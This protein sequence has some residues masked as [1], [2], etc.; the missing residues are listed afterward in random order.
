[1]HQLPFP[2]SN[3]IVTSPFELIHADLWGTAPLVASNSFRFY[4]VFVDEFTKFTWVY[5]LKHM[6]DTFQVF[7]QFR[8]MIETQFSLP[9]KTLRTDCGGEILS[10]PFNQFCLSKG[11]LHQLSCPHTPQ[12]NGVALGKHRHL[13]HC[14][15]ALL[16]QSKLPM[17]YWSYAISTATHLINKLPT[18]NLGNQSPW[19]LFIMFLLI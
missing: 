14:A 9:I 13:V 17:S 8:D 11:I 18:P 5:L 19:K 6:S 16:S 2:T 3:K 15:V 12:Q 10:T 7:T 1:M 4:L